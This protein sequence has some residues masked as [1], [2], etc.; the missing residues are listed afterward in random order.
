MENQYCP[1]CEQNVEP[2]KVFNWMTFLLSI[3]L[4][5]MGGLIYLLY[6][7]FIVKP[8][9]LGLTFAITAVFIAIGFAVYLLYYWF[10]KTP[11]CPMCGN[12]SLLPS[13]ERVEDVQ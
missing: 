4:F 7:W 6:N 13:R 3:S 5:G 12:L 1:Q 8:Q 10:F 11:Q 9:D 2:I